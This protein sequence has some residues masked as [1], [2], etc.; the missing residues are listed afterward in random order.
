MTTDKAPSPKL[1]MMDRE[2]L[3]R[4][5]YP[6]AWARHDTLVGFIERGVGADNHQETY[7][8][9]WRAG[10]RTV[11]AAKEW[12]MNDGTRVGW[13]LRDSLAVADRVIAAITPAPSENVDGAF[14]RIEWPV[15]EAEVVLFDPG[16]DPIPRRQPYKIIDASL[17]FMD[18][19]AIGERLYTKAQVEDI[20]RGATPAPAPG[21]E[22]S[23]SVEIERLRMVLDQIA[24][25]T[26]ERD[27]GL[28]KAND[29]IIELQE[30]AAEALESI[31]STSALEGE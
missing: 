16:R 4:A 12:L 30:L 10:V 17:W 25:D 18:K 14:E 3:A 8:F 11:E 29:H 15:G 27:T 31:A 6:A 9:M 22:G 24:N 2:Y 13:D 28:L 21:V 20:L 7:C 5:I 19:A 1:K 26:G 23:A